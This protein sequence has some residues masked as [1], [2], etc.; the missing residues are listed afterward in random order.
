MLI[1]NTGSWSLKRTRDKSVDCLGF[2]IPSSPGDQA[3]FA[4]R[5]RVISYV[6]P[7]TSHVSGVSG[8]QIDHSSLQGNVQNARRNFSPF[9]HEI[10][11]NFTLISNPSLYLQATLIKSMKKCPALKFFLA[12][13]KPDLA[14]A[15]IRAWDFLGV[16][17][18]CIW[19]F[20]VSP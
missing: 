10:S 7:R 1:R 17:L 20:F 18:L 4:L 16:W 8:P 9:F 19:T 13:H 2:L 5:K 11:W 14:F 15:L 3:E 6:A 12:L